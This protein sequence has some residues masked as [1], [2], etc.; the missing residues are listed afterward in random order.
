M[1]R[2]HQARQPEEGHEVTGPA[3]V[4]KALS[5]GPEYTAQE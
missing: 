3:H 5:I 2:R 1:W 4:S